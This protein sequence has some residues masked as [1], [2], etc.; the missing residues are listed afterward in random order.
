[1]KCSDCGKRTVRIELTEEERAVG[2]VLRGG[3]VPV[4]IIP[5]DGGDAVALVGSAK[6]WGKDVAG[7]YSNLA[8]I[9]AAVALESESD[10]R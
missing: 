7:V 8:Y 3:L 9:V 4:T 1:M 5:A 10:G 2:R 6:V